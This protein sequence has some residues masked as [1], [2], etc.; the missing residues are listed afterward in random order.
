ME[1]EYGQGTAFSFTV[2]FG[3]G[4]EHAE[5]RFVT[6]PDLRGT[7]ALVVDDNVTSR[8]ILKD[9][10][11]SFTFEVTVAASGAEGISALESAPQ[12]QPFEL[13]V[14]DW[15]MPEMDGIEASQWIKN[16]P[17]LIKIPAIILVTAYGREEV[18]QQAEQVELDGILLKPVSPSVLF[19]A[20]MQAFGEAV[21]EK[22]RVG[23]K[24]QKK[25][26]Y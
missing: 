3:L 6:S 10:L 14:M 13:V 1:S 24:G 19:D 15:K 22:S 17:G 20:T 9:M 8:E 12:D 25:P 26:R 16:H 11:E 23:R 5:N 21:V 7:K 18:M 4:K 2:N